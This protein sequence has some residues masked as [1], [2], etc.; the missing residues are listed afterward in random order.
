MPTV[1]SHSIVGMGI[2]QWPR[3]VKG[4]RLLFASIILAALPDTDTILMGIFG[5]D[6]IFRH[7]GIL[8]SVFFAIVSAGITVWLFRHKQWISHDAVWKLF[9]VLFLIAFSHPLLDG[10]STGGYIGVAYLAPFDNTRYV[11]GDLLPLAPLGPAKLLSERGISL[12]LAEAGMLWTFAIGSYY[13]NRVST[14][15]S[16]FRTI[17]ACFWLFEMILWVHAGL[18]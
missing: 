16:R 10:Y 14:D 7:R 6:S 9:A 17:A 2:A 4:R 11:L 3:F 12:F 1:I 5:H 15:R 8:H 18:A 13:W